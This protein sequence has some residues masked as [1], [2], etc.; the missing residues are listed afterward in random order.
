MALG[1]LAD[2]V[3]GL[4]QL[5]EIVDGERPHS[6]RFLLSAW[7]LV[8]TVSMAFWRWHAAVLAAIGNWTVLGVVVW[9]L[10]ALY[11]INATVA[12]ITFTRRRSKSRPAS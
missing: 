1:A 4:L 7:V 6:W 11:L 8:A 2:I 3:V 12:S 10:F 5:S 9:L